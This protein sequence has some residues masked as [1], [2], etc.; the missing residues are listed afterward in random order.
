M[1]VLIDIVLPCFNPGNKWPQE[2]ESFYQEASQQF[3]LSFIVVNDGTTGNKVQEQV[4]ALQQKNIP[5]QL[6]SYEVNKGKGYA[7]RTGIKA[8][9]N[10]LVVY[11]DVDFPFTN[12]SMLA[13]MQKLAQGQNDVVAGFRSEAYYQK[14]MSGFRKL[15]SK[16]FRF[17]IRRI[18]KITITDTQCGLKGFNAKGREKFLNT[19]INRYLFDFEFIYTSCKDSRLS[20][21]ATEVQ[22]KDNVV[23]SKMRLKV[24]LQELVNL[25]LVLLSKKSG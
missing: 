21:G 1:P 4:M 20:V 8:A 15:L 13:L 14:K 9:Q 2:L 11:T 6:I 24:L 22:L 17:F 19:K 12:Q 16:A 18:L 10:N 23:F 5:V 7:L 25:I 3:G